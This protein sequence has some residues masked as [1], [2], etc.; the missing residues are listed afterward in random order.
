MPFDPR[1][2]EWGNPAGAIPS[3]LETKGANAGN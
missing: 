1:I 3:P 2:S